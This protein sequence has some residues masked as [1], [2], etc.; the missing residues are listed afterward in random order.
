MYE[1]LRPNILPVDDQPDHLKERLRKELEELTAHIPVGIYQFRMRTDGSI[2]FDF[3]NE[4]F[5]RLLGRDREEVL[6]DAA[7]AFQAV[8]PEERAA[9]VRLNQEAGKRRE[10]FFWIGRFLVEGKVR[11]LQVHS[12]PSAEPNGEGVWNGVVIDMTERK[13]LENALREAKREADAANQAKSRFLATMSHEIRT[14]MN[15]ILGMGETLLA[16]PRLSRKE[17]RFLEIA[18]KAG[19]TLLALINDVLD[20]SKIEA[21]QLT[22]EDI[23]FA[24]LEEIRQVI[25]MI[26]ATAQAKGVEL[27]CSPAANLPSH[28]RGDPQRLRQI[29]LNLLSNAVKFTERGSVTLQAEPGQGEQVCFSVADTG[30]GIPENRLD[31]IFQPFVQAEESTSR[32]FGGTGLGLSIC[33]QLVEKM[34]GEI[35]V[36]SQV[37]RGSLFRF[38]V[39]LPQVK[40]PVAEMHPATTAAEQHAHPPAV[41][42]E[43]GM[44]ILLVDDLEDNRLVVEAF[45]D[46]TPHQVVGAASGAE[47]IRLFESDSFD[48]VLMDMMM[49]GMDGLEATRNMRRIEAA[50]QTPRTPVV[51]LTANAMQEDMREA[52][53]AGCD[54]HISKPMRRSSL[55]EVIS[56]YCPQVPG[57]GT[58]SGLVTAS[59]PVMISQFIN[60]QTLDRLQSETGP[61]FQR[62]LGLFLKNFPDRL[63]ALSSAWQ[64]DNREALRQAA[65]KL[66]GTAAT[67]G[68]EQFAGCCALLEQAAAQGTIM[69]SIPGI[70]E[71]IMAEGERTRQALQRFLSDASA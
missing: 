40:A 16:S 9:F 42:M 7:T 51:A 24:P 55:L 56:L 12:L 65:H 36:E 13:L 53:L 59:E 33:C 48:L 37:G 62:V 69:T 71:E 6:R 50:R 54:R 63:E 49:P 8:H 45:L 25:S 22:L 35:W 60:L 15:T 18:N 26:A 46:N 39:R 67:F 17:K 66:K 4:P 47:A 29:L 3:V 30:I 2:S 64:A 20:L 58:S 61:G 11:W 68:A 32:R 10:S 28:V 41:P 44:R 38:T 19:N 1:T 57:A 52:L 27:I 14:P 70:L 43:T 31:T 21:G 34:G 5:C 23:P